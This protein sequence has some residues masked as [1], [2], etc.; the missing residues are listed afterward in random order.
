MTRK[1]RDARVSVRVAIVLEHERKVLIV[2]HDKGG[3]SYWVFPGGRLQHGETL[4]ECGRRELRE[5]THIDI[6]VGP[7]LYVSDRT[8][9]ETKEVNLFF[10]GYI[11]S[12]SPSLGIDPEAGK[13]GAVLKNLA[14]VTADELQRMDVLPPEIKEAVLEDWESGFRAVG[15]YI[16]TRS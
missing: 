9:G 13:E 1:N 3:R 4:E 7:L 2:M 14:F 6:R 8:S 10:R 15:R 12:G 16:R 11:D 5:E